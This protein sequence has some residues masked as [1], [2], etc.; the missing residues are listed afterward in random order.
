MQS[1]E[2]GLLPKLLNNIQKRKKNIS[3]SHSLR[4]VGIRAKSEALQMMKA[5]NS[6]QLSRRAP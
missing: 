5:F 6:Y 2:L 1:L 4:R 3:A